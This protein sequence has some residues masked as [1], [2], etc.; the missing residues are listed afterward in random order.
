M[1]RGVLILFLGFIQITSTFD[2]IKQAEAVN[3]TQS[4]LDF[5]NNKN[6]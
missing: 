4:I 5:I 3:K 6:V 2:T 1:I